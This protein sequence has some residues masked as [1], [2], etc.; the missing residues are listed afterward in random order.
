MTRFRISRSKRHE[1]A[2][3]IQRAARAERDAASVRAV[4]SQSRVFL[5]RG[6]TARRRDPRAAIGRCWIWRRQHGPI[7]I[8]A[9]GFTLEEIAR[10]DPEWIARAKAL[11]EQ[12]RIELIGSGYAQIIGPLVPA[13]V[14]QANLKIGNAIYQRAARRCAEARAGERAGLFGG[15]CRPLSRRGLSR[16]PDGLGQ[17]RRASSRMAGRH[18]PSAAMR[19][20]AAMGA[21]SHFCGRS[22]V[23]FQ[24]LQRFAHGDIEL[25]EYL[26]YIR[27]RRNGETA[28]ALPLRQRRGDLRFPPRPLSHRGSACRESEWARLGK[29]FAHVSA[30]PGCRLIAPSEALSLLTLPCAGQRLHLESAACPVPVKKQRKY[31]LS[32]WAVT[33]RD[34]LGDQRGV[35]AD[36]RW[37]CCIG[38]RRCGVERAL[39]FVGERFPHAYHGE[40]LGGICAAAWRSGGTA[41]PL[42]HRERGRG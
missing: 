42:P 13:R 41:F 6:R 35:S 30:E 39:L 3:E 15:T 10:A 4:P 19:A 23:A 33:G 24:K 17:S 29:A 31:N 37:P 1:R 18:A 9:T 14:T 26:D 28:R 5:D 7:G 38:R 11:I 22:T 27:A 40:A 12:G 8:E 20:W 34:D 32:R 2:V 21:R 25:D 16:D 36:L